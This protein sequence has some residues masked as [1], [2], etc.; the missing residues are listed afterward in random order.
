[1]EAKDKELLLM[2]LCAR[3]PYKV[4]CEIRQREGSSPVLYDKLTCGTIKGIQ[5]YDWCVKPYLRPMS[6]MTEVEYKEYYGLCRS[7]EDVYNHT[8]YYDTMESI[9]YLN[10]HHLDYRWLID[11]GLALE[12][13]ADMYND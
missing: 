9:D 6:S 7:E 13:P 8:Y 5:D 10:A 12:A 11:M 4:E 2:D 1:M 3:L